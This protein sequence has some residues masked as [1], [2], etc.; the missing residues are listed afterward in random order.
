VA[1]TAA[2][3]IDLLG[4]AAHPTCG[5]MAESFRS[6]LRIPESALPAGFQGGREFGGCLCFLVT[7]EA[8]VRLHRIRSD[9]VYL[10]HQG[11]PL[12]VLLLREGGGH[13]LTVIGPDM[14]AGMRPQLLVPGGAFHAARVAGLRGWSLMSTAV[15]A[16]AEPSDVEMGDPARLTGSHPSAAD[17]ITVFAG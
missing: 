14:A 4:L 1:L 17:A 9:Q 11:E 10:H 16:R 13:E 2:Q 12:E 8:P 7:P 15:W 6:P 5:F 3:I